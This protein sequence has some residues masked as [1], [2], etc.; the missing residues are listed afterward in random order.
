MSDGSANQPAR[1]F[2]SHAVDWTVGILFYLLATEV[3][4]VIEFSDLSPILS[5][6]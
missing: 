6:P 4:S 5:E 1:S 2:S 3:L